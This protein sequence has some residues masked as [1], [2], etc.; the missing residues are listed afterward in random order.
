MQN[1]GPARQNGRRL[2]ASDRK[3]PA[4]V[5]VFTDIEQ[6]TYTYLIDRVLPKVATR[7]QSDTA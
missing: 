5:F 4:V 7:Y 3:S 2:I 1:E 6:I